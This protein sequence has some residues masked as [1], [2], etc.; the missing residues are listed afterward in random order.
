[1]K[2]TVNVNR[3]TGWTWETNHWEPVPLVTFTQSDLY[4]LGRK[5]NSAGGS[6]FTYTATFPNVGNQSLSAD[7]EK[8][9]GAWLQAPARIISVAEA[10]PPTFTWTAPTDGAA[11]DLGPAGGQAEVRLTAGSDQFQ[12]FTVSITRDGLPALTEQFSGTSYA[13]TVTFGPA[14]LGS[15]SISVKCADPNGLSSTQT[16]SLT[17][18][19]SVPPTVALDP[20]SDRQTLRSSPH[21]VTLTGR[22]NGAASG[23]TGV[24]FTFTNGPSGAAQDTSSGRDWSAWRVQ[25]PLAA[26]GTYPFRV[27]V[28]NSRGSTVSASG[29]ITLVAQGPPVFTWAA[30]A[31]GGVVD[32]GP[33]GG[34]IAVRLTSGSDQFYPFTVSIAHDGLP[35]TTD[36]YTGTEFTKT[37]MFGPMP[38]GSRSISVTCA[39][40]NG[41]S[42]TQTRSLVGRDSAPPTVALDPF[43]GSQTATSLPHPV[44][45][46]GTT[47][48][49][50]SGIT[51]VAYVFD[52]GPSGVAQ[53]TSPGGDWSTWRVRDAL[54]T[55]GT[56][57]F[58]VTVTN[59]RG[60][61]VSASGTIN[62]HL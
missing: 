28:T 52:N 25:A 13:K 55:T 18:R 44:T 38:L 27:T 1:M 4:I 16:R 21:T 31:D 49:A 3:G 19:D 17:G 37:V 36:Q 40:P 46:T 60:S 7:A 43:E 9:D 20:F 48:G 23:I 15:R 51:E 30:P 54:P 47:N 34:Q 41:L 58:R 61:T 33:D 53:D 11:V 59:S 57:T 26:I 62:L 2:I 5:I 24:A 12:P 56:Y 42:S 6:G 35:V 22:T 8:S 39:D 14:P 50:Q 45:L 10:I 29:T 32:L